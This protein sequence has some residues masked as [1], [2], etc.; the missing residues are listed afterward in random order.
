MPKLTA[1]FRIASPS[2]L[3][4]GFR[5]TWELASELIDPTQTFFYRVQLETFDVELTLFLYPHEHGYGTNEIEVRVSREEPN[6]ALDFHHYNATHLEYMNVAL[7]V[8]NR[9]VSYFKYD[10]RNPLLRPLRG[11]DVYDYASL[12]NT[13]KL[14]QALHVRFLA[15]PRI[16]TRFGLIMFDDKKDT[17]LNARLNEPVQART[18]AEEILSDAQAAAYEGNIRRATVELAVACEVAVRRTFFRRDTAYAEFLFDYLED[19]AQIHIVKL[20]D[21]F[22]EKATGDSFRKTHPKD[23]KNI[24]DLFIAR[25]TASHRGQQTVSAEVLDKW[26]NS[27]LALMSWLK[28]RSFPT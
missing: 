21:G 9:A 4:S 27:A 12:D 19:R 17:E 8:G 1:A 26:W 22:A 3:W 11:I 25:N 7:E 16:T 10:L 5:P 20:I 2:P 28:G 24:E 6:D 23:Y 15:E 13:R 18:L 14:F